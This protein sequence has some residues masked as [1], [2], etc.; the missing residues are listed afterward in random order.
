M[1][2]EAGSQSRKK[3]KS[4]VSTLF[5]TFVISYVMRL[6]EILIATLVTY[7]STRLFV[8]EVYGQLS[9][10]TI[11]VGI[12]HA[13]GFGWL[14][15]AL[16][17]FG[18][19]EY[20][21]T[22]SV[23]QT[24]KVRLILLS[25]IWLAVLI[26]FASFYFLMHGNLATWIGLSS[27]ILW[28]IPFLLTL[29]VLSN[30]LK[31]YLSVFGK[32]IPL[33]GAELVNQIVKVLIVVLLYIYFR[34]SGIGW[35]LFLTAS[36]IVI[37]SLYLFFWLE[38]RSFYL[39]NSFGLRAS[40]RRTVRYS[41]P[42]VGT[43]TMSYVYKPIEIFL[44]RHFVSMN[45][46]GL[47]SMAY[48]LSII[49]SSF[50][51]LF[52]NLT[53][54]ILQGIKASENREAMRRYYQNVVPQMTILFAFFTSMCLP[55]LPFILK[56][57]LHESYHP[58]IGALLLLAYSEIIHFPTA[59][60]S[61]YSYIYDK[62]SQA[63]WVML[64]QYAFQIPCYLLL[65]PRIGIE[66]AAWSWVASNLASSLLLTHYV[67]QEFGVSLRSYLAIGVSVLVGI[68]SLFLIWSEVPFGLQVVI[69][70]GI[71]MIAALLTKL[72]KLFDRRD[73]ELLLTVGVPKS[74]QAPL[75]A[76]YHA[77]G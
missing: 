54:P 30:E 73:A 77:L 68:S 1:L 33:G 42:A 12:F 52:P 62:M 7:F 56:S 13:L 22:G 60:Q 49:F 55:C 3:V 17:R 5:S 71:V 4:E 76:I 47:F 8:P 14:G 50:V 36:G 41:M 29:T 44:I 27:P 24:F 66:G 40:I 16:I 37:Q 26:I 23:C 32:Y 21:Q 67:S 10:I 58:A 65:I 20:I 48:S 51:M 31:G 6:G 70:L 75:R 25:G 46:V 19:E 69:M 59:L 53:F 64:L 39:E 61:S 72:V 9:M 74:F 43:S 57:F 34:T 38:R 18:K 2:R 11:A 15:T 35:L 28:V 45:G 63:L